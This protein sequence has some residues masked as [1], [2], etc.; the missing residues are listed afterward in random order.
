M[1]L[2]LPSV[3]LPYTFIAAVDA[4]KTA[5][6]ALNAPPGVDVNCDNFDAAD[7]ATADA[8]PRGMDRWSDDDDDVVVVV[9]SC[10]RR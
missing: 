1:L 8:P 10:G 7:D 3:T 5:R 2:L 6:A 9:R 4:A